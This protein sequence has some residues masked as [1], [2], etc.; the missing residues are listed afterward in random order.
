MRLV[1][2]SIFGQE[3]RFYAAFGKFSLLVLK[4]VRTIGIRNVNKIEAHFKLL[5]FRIRHLLTGNYGIYWRHKVKPPPKLY[6]HFLSDFGQASIYAT[7]T[8]FP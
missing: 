5:F 8:K 1:Q 7:S 6:S 3:L 2:R 4:N